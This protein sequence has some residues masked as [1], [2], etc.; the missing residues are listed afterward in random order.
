MAQNTVLLPFQTI[1]I[2]YL[3]MFY[4]W[5]IYRGRPWRA[6]PIAQIYLPTPLHLFPPPPHNP[7][8]ILDPQLFTIPQATATCS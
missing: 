4:N 6:L 1:F 7:L 3:A 2:K 8:A 5:R